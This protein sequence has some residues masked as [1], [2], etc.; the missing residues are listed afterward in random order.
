LIE[1]IGLHPD[2]GSYNRMKAIDA[3]A[4]GGVFSDLQK[5]AFGAKGTVA[6]LT[7]P[8]T[9]EQLDILKIK[10]VAYDRSGFL[11]STSMSWAG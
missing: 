1:A 8:L 11:R 5:G 7:V 2:D 3:K 10:F 9:T 6:R 4:K